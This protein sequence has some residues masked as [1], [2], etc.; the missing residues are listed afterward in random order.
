MPLADYR[1]KRNFKVTPEPAGS[2]AAAKKKSASRI[3]VI[4]K[5][6][7]SRLHYDFRLELN[8]TLLSWA[9]PKGPSTDPAVKRLAMQVEDHPLEYADFEGVIP[10]GEYGGGTV[11]L[12]DRGTWEP[13][14]PDPAEALKKGDFKFTLYGKKLKG[15]WVLVRTRGF[16]SKPS[17]TSWLLI[18]HRDKFASKRDVTV[19]EPYSVKT[20]RLLADIAR[21]GGGNV[22]LAASGDPPTKKKRSRM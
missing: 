4:Q 8:G 2:A 7:A 13:E 22:E 11:M 1:K 14:L 19:T 12:W 9:V 21:A 3:Y 10:E 6:R 20:H 5:H 16:G 18:K 15:S 17:T